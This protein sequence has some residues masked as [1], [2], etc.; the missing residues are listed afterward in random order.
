MW[1]CFLTMAKVT[2][3]P[4]CGYD[5]RNK[6]WIKESEALLKRYNRETYQI[7]K[8]TINIAGK[9]SEVHTSDV[10]K[11][12]LGISTAETHVVFDGCKT[13]LNNEYYHTKGLNYVKFIILNTERNKEK[14]KKRLQ[15]VIGGKSVEL[16]E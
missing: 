10:Y 1:A 11:F 3:C 4:A 6:N 12:L 2:Y 14:I 5:F 15:Y 7:V 8:K 13:F 16:N 9:Y